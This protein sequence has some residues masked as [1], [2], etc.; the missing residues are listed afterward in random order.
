M[1]MKKGTR[2][3]VWKINGELK[4]FQS[5]LPGAQMVVFASDEQQIKMGDMRKAEQDE[6][7][8]ALMHW[9]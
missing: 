8:L 1:Q 4:G 3:E 2:E 6:M 7:Y 5:T 9:R